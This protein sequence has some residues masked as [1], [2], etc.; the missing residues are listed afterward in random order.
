MRFAEL[1][2]KKE[3]DLTEEEKAE[4]KALVD[5]YIADCQEVDKKHGMEKYGVLYSSESSLTAGM[6]LR[7]LKAE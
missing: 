5:A 6:R 4:L 1:T 7:A 3:E 2:A